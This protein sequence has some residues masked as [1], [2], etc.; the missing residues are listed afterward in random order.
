[1]TE[2]FE[3]IGII[4]GGAWGTALAMVMQ[5]AGRQP[6][7]WAREAEVVLAINTRHENNFFLPGIE[8]DPAIRAT[9]NIADLA[10][11]DAVLMVAPT[12]HARHLSKQFAKTSAASRAPILICAKGIEQKTGKLLSEIVAEELPNH[13]LAVLSGPSFATEVAR[14]KPAAVTLAT[15]DTAIGEKLMQA[16]GTKHFRIYLSDD[17]IGAQIGAAIKNVL[18]VACG[19]A[20]G[21]R[22]GDN[23]RAALI[24]RG[25]AEMMRLG[26]AMGAQPETLMG[27]SGLGDLVLTCSSLQS[28]NM[29]LGSA[30]GQGNHSG[31]HFGE[32]RRH[33]RRRFHGDRGHHAGRE[34]QDRHADR[35]GGGCGA[36]QGRRSRRNNRRAAGAAI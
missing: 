31:R 30:L 27:L 9:N 4:G 2:S 16:L 25:L 12:Q 8:L 32:T 23:T 36:E 33:H 13:P 3:R 34:I 6:L 29:S 1:M 11:C 22:M 19:I 14:D 10:V 35:G 17:I 5:R 7:L 18:A 24:T 20:A 26:A 21:C 15:K 28:R